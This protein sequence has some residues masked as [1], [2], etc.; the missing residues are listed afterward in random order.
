MAAARP[1]I[2]WHGFGASSTAYTVVGV[3]D[4]NGDGVADVL[5][6]DNAGGDTGSGRPKEL[7]SRYHFTDTTTRNPNVPRNSRPYRAMKRCGQAIVAKI[8][9]SKP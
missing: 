5:W 2:T 3:G 4:F 6:R 9:Q 1:V 8:R 7:I